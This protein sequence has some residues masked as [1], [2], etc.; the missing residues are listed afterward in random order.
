MAV[1]EERAVEEVSASCCE[2]SSVTRRAVRQGEPARIGILGGTFDPIHYG[3]LI[4][5]EEAR[6]QIPLD[7]VLFV[8]AARPPHKPDVYICPAHHR[9]R[10]IELAIASNP[11]FEVSTV[12]LY[13]PGPSYSLDMIR[14]LRQECGP[15]AELYF[16]MGMDSLA[17]ILSWHEPARLLG[18][19][20]LAVARRQGYRADLSALEAELP[21]I[22]GRT[23]F[24][25]TPEYGVSS[26]DIER[27]HRRPRFGTTCVGERT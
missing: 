6:F 15:R 8:P 26:S 11:A 22:T 18:L 9:L 23:T 16:I 27:R 10:M 3:H 21:D 7:R 20:R 25:D 19:C 1:R 14:L 2:E 17:G 12:D 5:A 13:R 24:L 4:I